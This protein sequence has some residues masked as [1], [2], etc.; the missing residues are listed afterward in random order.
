MT[1]TTTTQRG[2]HWDE[3]ALRVYGSEAHADFLMAHNME[4]LDTQRFGAG[5]TMN[6]PTI[7]VEAANPPPWRR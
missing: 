1:N 4:L 5:T 6:T 3:I 7:P 2:E